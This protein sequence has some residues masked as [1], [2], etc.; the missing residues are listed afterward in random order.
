MNGTELKSN[1]TLCKCG[2][3][4]VVAS[5]KSGY[6]RGHW[7]RDPVMKQKAVYAR[8]CKKGSCVEE[9]AKTVTP[10][11]AVSSCMSVADMKKKAI[12]TIIEDNCPIEILYQL[13]FYKPIASV[14]QAESKVISSKKKRE[15][16]ASHYKRWMKEEL[17]Y[18]LENYMFFSKGKSRRKCRI[19]NKRLASKLGR[20]YRSIQKKAELLRINSVAR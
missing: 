18:L 16:Q 15:Y 17:D 19:C 14:V 8:W 6:A 20:T 13:A 2:C 4:R 1:G 10:V 3:G 9:K 5:G 7:M 11:G 12:Q